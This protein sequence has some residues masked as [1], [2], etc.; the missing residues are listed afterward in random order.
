MTIKIRK[1]LR[2][3]LDKLKVRIMIYTYMVLI[4]PTLYTRVL[5]LL[6]PHFVF[7][8]LLSSP[9]LA[10]VQYREEWEGSRNGREDMKIS[11]HGKENNAIHM[12]CS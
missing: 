12:L 7:G 9:S 11:F 2:C 6:L 4:L 1:I 5:C 10:F 3:F 8:E